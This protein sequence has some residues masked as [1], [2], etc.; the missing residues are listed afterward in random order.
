MWV[1]SDDLSVFLSLRILYIPMDL[2]HCQERQG[3]GGEYQ[4][5]I[6]SSEH[7]YSQT[8]GGDVPWQQPLPV[9][10]VCP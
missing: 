4:E 1:E 6:S 7:L 8:Q 9:N 5:H 2:W 10:N 3:A